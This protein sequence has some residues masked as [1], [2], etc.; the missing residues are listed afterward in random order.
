MIAAVVVPARDEEARIG[1]CLQ[2]LAAQTVGGDAF[3]V[4]VVLDACRDATAEV[5]EQSRRTLGLNLVTV[6]GPGT[7]PGAARRAGMD[8]ACAM[9]LEAD[10]GGRGLIAS[11]D[12][13]SRPTADWLERQDHHVSEGA[14]AIAGMIELDPDEAARLGPEV[15]AARRAHAEQRLARVRRLDPGAEHHH[16]GGASLAVTAATYRRIGGIEPVPELEDATFER[17]LAEHGVAV[18]RAGDVR[19]T[20]S[21][22]S[23]GRT[24]RGLAVDIAVARWCTTG[25]RR[26][27]AFAPSRV[28]AE[29]GEAV[30]TVIVGGD[31]PPLA[32]ARLL[33]V[34]LAG[35]RA[36][37]VGH[38]VLVAGGDGEDPDGRGP[39][40]GRGDALQ[41]ALR[42]GT[43]ELVCV[44]DPAAEDDGSPA[45]RV[46]GLIGPL[47]S[48]P[49]LML[50]KA[51]AAPGRPV[52][53][54]GLGELVARPLIHRHRPRLV[55]FSDP[56]AR[57]FAARRS[58]LERVAFAAGEGVELGILIDALDRCGLS[59]LAESGPEPDPE[60]D[61]DRPSSVARATAT[62]RTPGEVAYA[63]HAAVEH[64]T[65]D[66]PKGLHE[67][68][69][70]YVNGG[71]RGVP[72]V[73][74]TAEL[75]ALVAP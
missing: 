49:G 72:G 71:A 14:L 29:Q 27:G 60:P 7:G 23:E 33:D 19:V 42:A 66:H 24:P 56:L 37:G 4:V 43:G 47:L 44:L 17:R 74:V 52:P 57:E 54:D 61:P 32:V 3:T 64:R 75:P 21:A 35:L 55:G 36:A 65:G 31:G 16:F 6:S 58:L 67:P 11:T 18:L 46:A 8:H 62:G 25:S 39:I 9:L 20:T 53:V 40:R 13:D 5:V 69:T 38:E 45:D 30:V 28:S 41:R 63:L 22:R 48:E 68:D 51:A 73:V 10:P 50:V 2:A 26:R 1:A 15:L 34:G 59:A 70:V 12:A